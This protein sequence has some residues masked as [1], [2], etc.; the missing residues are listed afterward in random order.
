MKVTNEYLIAGDLA[1]AP[2]ILRDLFAS[3]QAGIRRRVAENPSTPV[4]VLLSLVD[5]PNPDVRAS[6]VHNPSVTRHILERLCADS[7]ADVR[8]SIAEEPRLPVDLLIKMADDPNPYVKDVAEMTLEGISFENELHKEGYVHEEGAEARLG[9]LLAGAN[10]LMREH[11]DHYIKLGRD[12]G[13]PLGRL[14]VQENVLG[15]G[16]VIRALKL[17]SQVRKGKIS[18]QEAWKELTVWSSS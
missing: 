15:K 4:D 14:L 2:E 16:V 8:V 3:A 12:K 1:T 11:I 6:L 17:Q 7:D 18:Q 10:V 13:I 9:D 5:D